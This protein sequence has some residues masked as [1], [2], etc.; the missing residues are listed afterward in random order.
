MALDN[1]TMPSIWLRYRSGIYPIMNFCLSILAQLCFK[2]KL[3]SFWVHLNSITPWVIFTNL[4]WY[5]IFKDYIY[6]PFLWSD[7]IIQ[8]LHPDWFYWSNQGV[9]EVYYIIP[10]TKVVN[11][12]L[13]LS[14]MTMSWFFKKISGWTI[15]WVSNDLSRLIPDICLMFINGLVISNKISIIRAIVG[16]IKHLFKQG[17]CWYLVS[18]INWNLTYMYQR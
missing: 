18:L 11:V 6:Q 10:S 17:F 4:S 14:Q 9:I 8:T 2:I 5:P 13:C 7:C 12:T 15:L 1:L 16:Y 3:A